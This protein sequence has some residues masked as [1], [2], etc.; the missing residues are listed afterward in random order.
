[1]GV[2]NMVHLLQIAQFAVSVQST[3][4]TVGRDCDHPVMFIGRLTM[5]SIV[6]ELRGSNRAAC[7]RRP[8]IP[9]AK[10]LSYAVVATLITLA[11]CCCLASPAPAADARFANSSTPVPADGN[12]FTGGIRPQDEILL[13]DVRSLGGCCAPE[14]MAGRVRVRSYEITNDSGHRQWQPSDM[15][16]IQAADP[17]IA[18]MV[19]VH[20][21]RVSPGDACREGLAVYRRVVRQSASD[22]P[23]RFVIFSWPSSQIRGPLKDVRAKAA[24][25]QP[26]GLQLAWLVDQMPAETPVSLVGFSF[27]ARIVTGAL[28]ILGG[29]TL[30]GRTLTE[31]LNPNRA[32]VNAVLLV[33]ALHADWLAPGRYHGRA[34]SQVDHML[35]LNSRLDRAMQHY[36]F[37]TKRGKPQALGLRGPTCIDADGAGKITERDLGRYVGSN[38]NLFCYVS[39]PGVTSQLWES[40]SHEL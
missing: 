36:H 9:V 17:S 14:L 7:H 24:R 33:A 5:I 13:V 29:G 23:I 4:R 27:G 19:F 26:A 28:H 20:G 38:H 40:A 8:L 35:L 12:V 11:A 3:I 30:N 10:R 2:E 16:T 18:T 37:V 32:P 21:N 31:R 1:M 34:L 6:L 39:A 25:T 22:T 15:E